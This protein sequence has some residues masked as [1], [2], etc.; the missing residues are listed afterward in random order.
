[1]EKFPRVLEEIQF[2][3]LKYGE[4]NH[5]IL[6]SYDLIWSD[7]ITRYENVFKTKLW[8]C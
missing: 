2:I 8:N 6:S 4:N 3:T 7:Q 5:E 1:M